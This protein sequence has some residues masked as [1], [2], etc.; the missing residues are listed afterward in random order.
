MGRFRHLA[1]P[2]QN[3]PE[4]KEQDFKAIFGND[5][6]LVLE[7]GIGFGR[8]FIAMAQ[9]F[10]NNNFI[11]IEIRNPFVKIINEKI[12]KLGLKNALAIHANANFSLTKIINKKSI[13]EVYILFPD[14]WI[15]RK[16]LKRRLVH[17]PFIKDLYKV[18][19]RGTKVH[20]KTDEDFMHADISA[21]FKSAKLFK[22]IR[23][24]KL[25]FITTR[26]KKYLG[27]GKKIWQLTYQK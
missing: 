2:F 17:L 11:G 5:H 14:P 13:A 4:V 21:K 6:P 1:N 18:C 20:I 25:P 16:H 3:A 27:K 19:R 23:N 8:F 15:K 22:K 12:E 10:P 26:E 9:K 7:I 24:P